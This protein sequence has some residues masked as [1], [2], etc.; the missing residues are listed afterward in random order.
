MSFSLLGTLYAS[1]VSWCNFSLVNDF[2]ARSLYGLSPIVDE[3][4]DESDNY[5]S[6]ESILNFEEEIENDNSIA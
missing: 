5:D 4:I 2:S 3:S 6:D 1:R